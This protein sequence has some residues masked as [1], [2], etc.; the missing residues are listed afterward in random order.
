MVVVVVCPAS[1][2]SSSAR[3]V[4]EA[5]SAL[6]WFC[7]CGCGWGRLRVE[8]ATLGWGLP[9]C[10]GLAARKPP[11]LGPPELGP[12]ELGPVE[13]GPLELGPM[14]LEPVLTFV[15]RSAGPVAG[16][17]G[18]CAP[19]A[20]PVDCDP[21]SG[22]GCCCAGCRGWRAVPKPGRPR[23]SRPGLSLIDCSPVTT[24]RAP[25]ASAFVITCIVHYGSNAHYP[26]AVPV[27]PAR[28]IVGGSILHGLRYDMPV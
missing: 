4:L 21:T 25:A 8:K 23:V 1:S 5:A 2:P 19:L 3:E 28:G 11:E 9:P 12:P 7:G 22:C 18:D 6:V 10:T 26:F 16:R 24:L 20:L 13:L 17:G 14:E 15:P 27:T